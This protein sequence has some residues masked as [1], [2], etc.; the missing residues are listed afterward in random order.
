MIHFYQEGVRL[1][2]HAAVIAVLLLLYCGGRIKR[3]LWKRTSR[4]IWKSVLSKTV[5]ESPEK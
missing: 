3:W 1:S 4:R 5:S 2:Y